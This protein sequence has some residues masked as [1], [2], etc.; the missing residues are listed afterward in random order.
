ME[1]VLFEK[2]SLLKLALIG[3]PAGQLHA[4][5]VV[6]AI[7]E[8]FRFETIPKTLA[9]TATS[10]EFEHGYDGDISIEKLGI[11]N[12]GVVINSSS[13][14]DKLDA[15]LQILTEWAKTTL[16]VVVH[17][18]QAVDTLYESNIVVKSSHDL[19]LAHERMSTVATK[20]SQHLKEVSGIDAVFHNADAIMSPDMNRLPGLR[21]APFRIAR[22]AG[23]DFEQNLFFSSAPLTTSRHI[24]VLNALATR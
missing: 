17:K 14:T 8:R 19:V 3:R 1:I 7:Q 10:M 6:S 21:P 4:P 24:D 5:H 13:P 12:D 18:T 15:F 16:G 22:R 9:E 20:L 23:V 11:Y 2:S